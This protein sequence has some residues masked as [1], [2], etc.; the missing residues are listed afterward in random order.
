MRHAQPILKANGALSLEIA[1]EVL[2][3]SETR[4]YTGRWL[5]FR[6]RSLTPFFGRGPLAARIDESGPE[7]FG[8]SR[9][10]MMPA[11]RSTANGSRPPVNF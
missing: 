5:R 6:T 9:V 1:C 11:T 8:G 7:V 10:V 4:N 2:A 3:F